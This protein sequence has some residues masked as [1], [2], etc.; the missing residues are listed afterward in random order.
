MEKEQ[1]EE[2]RAE[3]PGKKQS[4]ALESLGK[5]GHKGS[6]ALGAER[7]QQ[8]QPKQEQTEV[9]RKESRGGG[10]L[11]QVKSRLDSGGKQLNTMTDG[12]KGI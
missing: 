8:H 9:S 7:G 1:G 6:A 5:C 3:Q 4:H 2:E 11:P 10:N 12:D